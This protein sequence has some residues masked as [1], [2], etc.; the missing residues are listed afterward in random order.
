MTTVYTC[1]ISLAQV[2]SNQEV[3][4]HPVTKGFPHHA[5]TCHEIS[6][7]GSLTILHLPKTMIS[8]SPT[9][10]RLHN[11]GNRDAASASLPPSPDNLTLIYLMGNGV[12]NSS[13][14]SPQHNRGG[15]NGHRT[16][17][18]QEKQQLSMNMIETV[19]SIMDDSII[20]DMSHSE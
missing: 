6:A 3:D 5:K 19:L 9:S 20:D 4:F 18:T 14:D 8:P 16:V 10:A 1:L 13:R 7:N 15:Q 17:S 2:V 12:R 11:G